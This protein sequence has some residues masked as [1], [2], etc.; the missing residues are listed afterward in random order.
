[1][2]F[3]S[4]EDLPDPG[5]KPGS[6]TL[7]ADALPSEPTGKLNKVGVDVFLELSCFFDDP[8]DVGK[9]DLWFLCLF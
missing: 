1:M 7:L 2:P 8:M 9:F 6:P 4:P 3:P 5:I